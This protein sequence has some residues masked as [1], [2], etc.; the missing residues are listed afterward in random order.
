VTSY[1]DI[2]A[3]LT[4]KSL[5]PDIENVLARSTEANVRS[6][7]VTGTT[8]QESHNALE[9]CRQ[10]PHQLWCTAGIHPHHADEWNSHAARVLEVLAQSP[11]VRAIGETG[12][13][14]NRD[15]SPRE[16]QI[17]AFEG[18]L[19]L[20]TQTGLPVFSHQRDAHDVFLSNL[21]EH[22][23]DLNA[24][25]VHCFTDNESALRDYLDMDCYIGIT[26]WLCDERR[27]LELQRIVRYIPENRI[28]VETDA[29][30]LL[31]RN[32]PNPTKKRIN[33][34]CNLPHILKTLADCRESDVSSLAQSC[35][36]NSLRFF[37]IK[38]P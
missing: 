29:P 9:L 36:A 7:V 5:L 35:Y 31:P 26:G 21:K 4:H 13:D 2:G 25:V 28:M 27:G 32:M 34:P 30:Y 37:G 6:I 33:E 17:T 22:R 11:Q 18:Q 3:N 10:F 38:Q 15:F 8:L 16:C 12:L 1:F 19:G 14:F 20:A 23:S 24:V